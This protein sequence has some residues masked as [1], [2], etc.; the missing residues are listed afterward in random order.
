[1]SRGIILTIYARPKAGT[2]P[3]ELRDC[4]A[5]YY[6][7]EPFVHVLPEATWPHTKWATGTNNCF[8]AVGIDAA[9]GRA[10]LVS[11][12]DNLGKGY[13]G[14]MVQCLNR[15]IGVEESCGLSLPAAYP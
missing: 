3:G 7:E 11:A 15:M 4:L 2:G 12:L 5:H 8:L 14:Q 13:A 6:E 9:T 1:M 10:I